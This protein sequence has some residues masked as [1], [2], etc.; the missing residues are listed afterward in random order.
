MT[1]PVSSVSLALDRVEELFAPRPVDPLQGRFDGRS[2][3]EYL[4]EEVEPS[5]EPL[6]VD[7]TLT[8]PSEPTH[9]NEQVSRAI[10]G[11]ADLAIAR[12]E[13]EKLRIRRLGLKELTFG[14]CFL[15]ACLLSGSAIAAFEL[16]PDWFRDFIVEGL[17]IVGWI[18]LW[19]PVDM[20]FFGRLPLIRE[21][22]VLDRLRNAQVRLQWNRA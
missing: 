18:A 10:V 1:V 2:G 12:V 7:I 6:V 13:A 9:T 15:L 22:R 16:G 20:L 17:I 4:V 19:H 5:R 21:Q 14:L 11:F 3:F 8:D